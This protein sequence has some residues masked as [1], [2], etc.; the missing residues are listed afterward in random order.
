MVLGT[1][2]EPFGMLGVG[3][4]PNCGAGLPD[5]G[6]LAVVDHRRGE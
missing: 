5:S 6:G 4:I 1:T 3:G 2:Y